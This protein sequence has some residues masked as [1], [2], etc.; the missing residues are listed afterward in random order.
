MLKYT[1]MQL[2][3]LMVYKLKSLQIETV[4]TSDL[5]LVTVYLLEHILKVN[6]LEAMS[7]IPMV[8][9]VHGELTTIPI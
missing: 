2:H 9:M 3:Q 1:S 6:Y 7:H 5:L 8:R 4:D